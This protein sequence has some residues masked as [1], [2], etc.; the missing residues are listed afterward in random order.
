MNLVLLAR[1][2]KRNTTK[3]MTLIIV[4][5]VTNGGSLNAAIIHVGFAK[6]D[7]RARKMSLYKIIRLLKC[8]H[9]YKVENIVSIC[10]RGNSDEMP[11]G[12]VYILQ[13]QRCGKIKK[14]RI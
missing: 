5:P 14:T 8:P 2:R 13:C 3:S 4:S 9:K 7:R 11:I 10:G 6:T 12:Q 1:R